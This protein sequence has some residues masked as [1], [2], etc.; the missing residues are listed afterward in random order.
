[1]VD[2]EGGWPGVA[3]SLV[4]EESD[5]ELLV[6]DERGVAGKSTFGQGDEGLYFHI[7]MLQNIS[8]SKRRDQ[9]NLHSVVGDQIQ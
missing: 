5:R 8:S 4:A 2:G 1:M 7:H 6:F 9:T 3:K